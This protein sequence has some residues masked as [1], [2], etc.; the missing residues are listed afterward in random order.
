MEKKI[1]WYKLVFKQNQPIHIGSTKWGIVN[2]TE[3]FI[4]GWTMWGALTITFNQYSKESKL[5][6]NQELFETITCFYPS[7]Y[8]NKN[9]KLKLNILFPNY[10]NGLLYLGEYSEDKFRYEFTDTF[11]S[12]AIIPGLRSAKEESLHEIEVLLPQSKKEIK[13]E[14]KKES[15]KEK[16]QLYWVGILGIKDDLPDFI[17]NDL[18]DFLKKGLNIYIGGDVKYGFG[19]LELVY[20]R[21]IE[22]K[23]NDELKNELKNW[24]IDEY[25]CLT[26][27][28][29]KNIKQFLE[30]SPEIKFEGELK[31][32]AEFDFT[33]N[34]P[35]IKN[36]SYFINIGS[37]INSKI[38]NLSFKLV[39]GK[40]EKV[41]L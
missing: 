19:E 23:D 15:K 30:F 10:K 11:V 37:K 24:N 27:D 25:G 34:I 2:K 14:N 38:P 36:V 29:N 3:I 26:L 7:F 5:S 8:E 16:K 40:F 33:K 35:E 13:E 6:G 21:E 28:D 12:T 41:C 22:S 32:L 1:K 4:P 17:K 31:L 20:D 18:S 9:N 39:K